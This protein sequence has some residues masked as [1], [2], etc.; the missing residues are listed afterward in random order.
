[1]K[2]VDWFD[3]KRDDWHKLRLATIA[4]FDFVCSKLFDRDEKLVCMAITTIGRL[5]MEGFEPALVTLR[6]YLPK[7]KQFKWWVRYL[8]EAV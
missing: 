4:D 6:G 3:Y 5:A 8:R 1:M 7:K 2:C